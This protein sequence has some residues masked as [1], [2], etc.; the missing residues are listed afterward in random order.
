[1]KELSENLK[2]LDFCET[3]FMKFGFHKTTMDDIAKELRISK[4]TIYKHF[5]TKND[6]VRAVFVRIRNDLASQ[7]ESIVNG[8]GNAII[9]LYNISQIFSQRISAISN[10]WLNDLQY[11]APDV[12]YEIEEFRK[13]MM[14]KNLNLLVNQG[15]TEG[16]VEDFPNSIILGII[17]SSVQGVVTP[18]FVLNNNISV[19]QAGI[20]TLDIVFSGILTKKGRKLF[21]QY[22]SG[23]S[24]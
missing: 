19:K 1:M 13:K 23:N 22:K 14:Y 24:Q 15:K 8:E 21:K 12:W 9:K 10:N 11:Y 4:K 18:E 3:H 6:L 7:I 17:I 20:M 2:I 5:Q 16:L